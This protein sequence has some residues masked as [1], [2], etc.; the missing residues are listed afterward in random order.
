MA[1]PD[2]SVDSP[3]AHGAGRPYDGLEPDVV[4]AAVEAFGRYCDGHLL[5]LNS[6]ENRVYQVGIEDG[7]P[8]IAKFYRPG[9]W[10]DEAILEEHEFTREMVEFEL[11]VAAPCLAADGASLVH[12]AGFR[13]ALFERRSGAWPEMFDSERRRWMG[14][15][16]AR[17]HAV[18]ATRPFQHRPRLDDVTFG[19]EPR[20]F[21]LESGQLPPGVEQ[22]Y[23]DT[24]AQ[25]LQ[26]VRERFAEAAPLQFIR[27][28]GDCHGSNVLWG[29]E[30]GPSFVDL[31]DSRMAPAVQDLWMFLEGSPDERRGQL[32]D[33][34]DGYEDFRSFDWRELQLV[35]ALR[36]LRLL[37]YSAWL[38]R[39]WSD[40]AFP[41]AF[42]WFGTDNYWEQ[43]VQNL[44][45]QIEALTVAEGESD[46]WRLH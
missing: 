39:R 15:L 16:L 2:D 31:D 30:Q 41:I 8:V 4:L 14:R 29:E 43:H 10:T 42:P 28:H 5:A 9:R 23:A 40:P 19:E 25:L 13:V 20:A 3:G 46:Q 44:R 22:R 6:Y 1:E 37:H 36:G 35:E 38:A 45:E 32:A 11:P 7:T 18:G 26:L 24:S 27:T 21:L 34:L 17:I 33:L 12:H